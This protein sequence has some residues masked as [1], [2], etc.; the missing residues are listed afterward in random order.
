MIPAFFHRNMNY[1]LPK[2]VK[3]GDKYIDVRYDFR[4]ILEIIEMLSDSDLSN[5]DKAEALIQMFYCDPTDITDYAEAVTE[6]FKFIDQGKEEP[7]KGPK[8]V[9]WEQDFDMIIAPVNRVIGMECR[10]VDYDSDTNIGGIHWWTFLSAYMEMGSDCL[11]SQVI[12]IRDKKARG[13]SLDKYEQKW[14][15]RNRE[16]VDMKHSYSEAE[17]ELIKQ[18]TGGVTNG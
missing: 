14:Y 1:S 3:N 16:L 15:I 8:L 6:C 10:A 17:E 2:S 9:N 12:S 5:E 13:I 18:W 7:K 4:V 11:F